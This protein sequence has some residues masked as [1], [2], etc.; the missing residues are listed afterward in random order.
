[1]TG[2]AIVAPGAEVTTERGAARRILSA[3]FEDK[4]VTVGSGILTVIL[5][6]AVFAPFVAPYD[7]SLVSLPDR[8]APPG[9]DHIL[10][11]DALGRDVLSRVI[12]GARTSMIIGVSVVIVAGMVGIGLGLLAG[13]KGGMVDQIIM[14][15]ADAQMAFPGLLLIIAIVAALGSSMQILVIV[16]SAS[17]WMI[18]ARLVRGNVLQLREQPFVRAAEMGGC[19]TARIMRKHLLPNLAALIMTQAMLELALIVQAE[20]SLS[21]LGLGIQPPQVSWGL[22]VAEN[23][24][25][26]ESGWW[27]IVFPGLA[28]ALTVLSVNLIASWLRIRTDPRQRATSVAQRLAR[29]LRAGTTKI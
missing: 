1:V 26:L 6:A 19:K 12:F 23:R 27:T 11:T 7:P 15:L 18:Y 21:F 25:Y 4:V 2:T 13:M 17:G 28:L 20:A 9:W 5:L 14:R 3:I 8:L 10:G 16:L 24:P 29:R 22:M